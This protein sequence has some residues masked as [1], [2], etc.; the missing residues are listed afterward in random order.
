MIG[1][2]YGP[3]Q[4]VNSIV[5]PGRSKKE[6]RDYLRGLGLSDWALFA[7]VPGLAAAN[8]VRKK[9][10]VTEPLSPEQYRNRGNRAYQAGR[11]EEALAAYESYVNAC[12]DVAQPHGLMGDALAALGRFGEASNA[13][14]RA[15]ENLARPTISIRGKGIIGHSIALTMSHSLY[16]N[17]GNVRAASGDHE[18]AVADFDMALRKGIDPKVGALFNRGNSR[19]ALGLFEEAH[20]DFQAAWAERESSGAALAMGNCKVMMGAFEEALERYV[21]GSAVGADDAAA[22]C[23][24][25]AEQVERLLQTLNGNDFS[26]NRDGHTVRVET[27]GLAGLFPLAGNR[28]NT[29]NIP[30]GMDTAP[31]GKGYEGADGFAVTVVSAQM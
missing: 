24:N 22:H 27:E 15:M 18:G 20:Q 28:G 7:D 5:V 8:A 2:P 11:F 23:Q 21:N 1:N 31:G 10:K 6:L 4:S 29:G 3:D 30:S 12:P 9:L 16:Y 17:R 13:Y 25:N 14:T 26:F 19:F